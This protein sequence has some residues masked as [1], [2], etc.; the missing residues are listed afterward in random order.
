MAP[1]QN[2]KWTG[3]AIVDHTSC[4]KAWPRATSEE[5][6]RAKKVLLELAEDQFLAKMLEG[7]KWRVE[8]LRE[9]NER[10]SKSHCGHNAGKGAK[11]IAIQL[12]RGPKFYDMHQILGIMMHELSHNEQSNHGPQ[13]KEKQFHDPPSVFDRVLTVPF[14]LLLVLTRAGARGR[15]M[16]RVQ[17]V[18]ESL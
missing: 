17:L 5:N 10:E 15:V 13:F 2:S 6:D 8:V 7:R 1:N 18:R 11:E 9:L 3:F 4:Y 14:L 16:E 12:R